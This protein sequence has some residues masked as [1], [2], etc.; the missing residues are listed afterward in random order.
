M[1]K[2]MITATL[3]LLTSTAQASYLWNNEPIK[4]SIPPAE[5]PQEI[6]GSGT[7]GYLWGPGVEWSFGALLG[8]LWAMY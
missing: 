4:D 2:A 5:Q 1:R 8:Y 7:E 3:V 6:G